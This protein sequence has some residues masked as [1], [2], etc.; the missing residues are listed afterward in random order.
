MRQKSLEHFLALLCWLKVRNTKRVF[1]TDE[2]IFYLNPP[3]SN[4]NNRVWSIGKKADVRLD[5]WTREVRSACYGIGWCLF[6]WQMST[7]FC[8][9]KS[10]CRILRVSPASRINCR[11]QTFA[12]NWIHLSARRRTSAYCITRARLAQFKLSWFH[13]EGPMASKLSRL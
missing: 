8:W 4:Q 3:I 1:F 2:K 6:R 7:A 9:C 11:L 10:E 5:R 12:A 13:W